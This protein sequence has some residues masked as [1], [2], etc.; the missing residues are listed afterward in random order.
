[1]ENERGDFAAVIKMFFT[2][3]RPVDKFVEFGGRRELAV[4]AELDRC[5]V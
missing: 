2:F 5:F 3:G 4:F 1:M